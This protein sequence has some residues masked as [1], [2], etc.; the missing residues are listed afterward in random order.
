MTIAPCCVLYYWTILLLKTLFQSTHHVIHHAILSQIRLAVVCMR[1]FY[2]GAVYQ[3][4]L[5]TSESFTYRFFFQWTQKN[6][7]RERGVP[8][9][10]L[11]W[12]CC[13]EPTKWDGKPRNTHYNENQRRGTTTSDLFYVQ[14]R[15]LL[16]L[17]L[18]TLFIIYFGL[19]SL[20]R[21]RMKR[22]R[23]IYSLKPAT[24]YVL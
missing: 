7:G 15:L 22:V 1:P 11:L 4:G 23:S 18:T 8:E 24:P 14:I 9:Y 10:F 3:P 21:F 2:W 12:I 6:G 13:V 20:D 5:S 17:L 16:Q 19:P